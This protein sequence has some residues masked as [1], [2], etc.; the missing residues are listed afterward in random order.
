MVGILRGVDREPVAQV[1]RKHSISEQ[2]IN[3]EPQR[4]S[5]MNADEM[6]RLR[7]LEH[8]TSRLKKILKKIA[9]KLW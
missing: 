2:A 7:R 3:T 6:K 1:A 5:G 8:D 9:T 4:F